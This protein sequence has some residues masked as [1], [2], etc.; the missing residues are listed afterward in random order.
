MTQRLYISKPSHQLVASDGTVLATL[1][2]FKSFG[3]IVTI[4]LEESQEIN[5][6]ASFSLRDD[7]LAGRWRPA[8]Q[9]LFGQAADSLPADAVVCSI[10]SDE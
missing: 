6:S 5:S 7:L 10:V 8:F 3:S 9:F 2:I 4:R 1:Q